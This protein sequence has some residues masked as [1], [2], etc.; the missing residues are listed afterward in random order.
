MWESA[1][2]ERNHQVAFVAH[3][4][5]EG[6]WSV[7]G[8]EIIGL[9]FLGELWGEVGGEESWEEALDTVSSGCLRCLSPPPS[10]DRDRIFFRDWGELVP[11]DICKKIS[12]ISMRSTVITQGCWSCLGF[13]FIFACCQTASRWQNCHK[14][15]GKGWFCCCLQMIGWWREN[16]SLMTCITARKQYSDSIYN[17]LYCINTST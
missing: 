8:R 15:A 16:S 11:V 17:C 10:S 9:P 5:S 1:I 3:Y 4:D 13:F 12:R 2:Q 7:G 6:A 14:Q